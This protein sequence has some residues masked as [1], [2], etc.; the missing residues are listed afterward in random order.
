MNI[1][2]ECPVQA[3]GVLLAGRRAIV[4][5]GL[6]LRCGLGGVLVVTVGGVV[7]VQTSPCTVTCADMNKP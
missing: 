4:V 5:A 1:P 6:C 7:D 3:S 2:D